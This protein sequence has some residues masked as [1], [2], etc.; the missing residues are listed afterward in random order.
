MK[1]LLRHNAYVNVPTHLPNDPP[2]VIRQLPTLIKAEPSAPTVLELADD[3][4]LDNI[5][6]TWEPMD[7]AAKKALAKLAEVREAIAAAAK[8][9]HEGK[10]VAAPAAAP[11]KV[12]AADLLDALASLP[13][14]E[15]KA[16]LAAAADKERKAQADAAA[17]E[18]MSGQNAK[19]AA[20]SKPQKG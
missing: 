11:A 3:T 4:S 7:E 2:G 9:K 1:F 15:R 16:L 17:G 8:A 5:S 13:E 18:T 6:G 19:T 14:A 20:A 12:T 10:P